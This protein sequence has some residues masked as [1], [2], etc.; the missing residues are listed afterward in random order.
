MQTASRCRRGSMRGCSLL[1]ARRSQE[2]RIPGTASLMAV[3]ASQDPAGG[4]W[5][6]VSNSEL[7]GRNGGAGALKFRADGSVASAYAILGGTKWNCA[8][9]AT[10]WR[11]WLSCEEHRAGY[12]WECDP[13]APGQ[14]TALPALGK[15][16]HEA[17]VVDTDTGYVYD[18]GRLR[19]PS[20]SISSRRMGQP[21]HRCARSSGV[22]RRHDRVDRRQARPSVPRQG[23]DAVLPRRG[24]MVRRWHRV[25]LHDGGSSRVGTRRPDRDARSD[26]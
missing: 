15:F 1:P 5:V 2:R 7:N 18:R 6:Y 16:P 26:L 12:V 17:A 23:H 11:T 4:G 14:G 20:L 13:Y 10:P 21:Q 8:G 19:E 3:R 22:I 9:G 24:R 25:F